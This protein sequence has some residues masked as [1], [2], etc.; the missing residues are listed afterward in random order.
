VLKLKMLDFIHDGGFFLVFV[1]LVGIWI[2]FGSRRAKWCPK[3][4]KPSCEKIGPKS[5]ADMQAMRCKFCGFNKII[6]T[7]PPNNNHE[8]GF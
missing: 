5:M 2:Y 6:H 4:K 7:P 1:A 8:G 3:C